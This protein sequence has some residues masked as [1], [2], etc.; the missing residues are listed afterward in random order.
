M[1]NLSGPEYRYENIVDG[2]GH[3]CF[4]E[5]GDWFKGNIIDSR[6]GSVF[7]V[8]GK[9][10]PD[11]EEDVT[12]MSTSLNSSC[13]S[14]SLESMP[15]TETES[16]RF[17]SLNIIDFETGNKQNHKLIYVIDKFIHFGWKRFNSIPNCYLFWSI[18][19]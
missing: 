1:K 15:G 16:C 3:F 10:S 14:S 12:L 6:R 2:V 11:L 5:D 17:Y 7:Q 19:L 13:E 9:A 4:A 18:G 8:S